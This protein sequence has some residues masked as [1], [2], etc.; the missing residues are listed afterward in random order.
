MN[1]GIKLGIAIVVALSALAA[2]Q[3]A[4]K[5]VRRAYEDHK[6]ASRSETTK[7]PVELSKKLTRSQFEDV[8]KKISE[9]MNKT[10]PSQIDSVTRIDS[11]SVGPGLKITYM[12]TLI[13]QDYQRVR[14][15]QLILD[16]ESQIKNG[17]C[18]MP[19]VRMFVENNVEMIY[20]YRR[21]NGEYIGEISV[22]PSRDCAKAR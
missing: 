20:R 4:S 14:K 3:F 7:D 21:E 9:D 5:A 15:E 13:G 10:L 2:G 12:H 22:L 19:Q 17:V 16:L 1:A 6:E 8:L 11:T 18:T